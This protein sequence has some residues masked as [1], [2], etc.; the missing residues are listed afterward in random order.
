MKRV[1][2]NVSWWNGYNTL[3]SINYMLEFFTLRVGNLVLI[4][5]LLATRKFSRLM[6]ELQGNV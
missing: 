4:L 2:G 1:S 5:V 3:D 6:L